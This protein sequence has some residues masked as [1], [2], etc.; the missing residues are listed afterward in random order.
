MVKFSGFFLCIVLASMALPIVHSTSRVPSVSAASY[1]IR[2]DGVLFAFGWSANNGEQWLVNNETNTMDSKA[3][4]VPP[5]IPIEGDG[6]NYQTNLYAVYVNNIGFDYG[7]STSTSDRYRPSDSMMAGGA[8]AFNT[9]GP[10]EPPTITIYGDAGPV[11]ANPSFIYF[12]NIGFS[13]VWSPNVGDKYRPSDSMIS[14]PISSFNSKAF[15]APSVPSDAGSPQENEA[16]IYLNNIGFSFGWSVNVNDRYRPSSTMEIGPL[17]SLNPNALKFPPSPA[18]GI[19]NTPPVTSDDYD[20]A[21]HNADFTI[22]LTAHDDLSGVAATYYRV[23]AGSIKRISIDGQPR[24]TTE[25]ANNT[26]EYWS[27]DNSANEELPHK[28]LF[29]IK[30]DKTSPVIWT[31]TR[32]PSGNVTANQAVTISANVT[33]SISG[34]KSARLE[35]NVSNSPL[36]WDFPMNLNSTTGLYEYTIP[37]QPAGALVKYKITA[38][39]YAGNNKV[40]DNAGQYYVY[41]VVPEFPPFLILPLFMIATLLAVIVFKRKKGK[42]LGC[43]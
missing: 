35:Y 8:L 20:G 26:L 37:G 18:V 33:D 29:G 24:I 43:E 4:A 22:T 9:K 25:S 27:V 23:N 14:G 16:L 13:T 15:S 39:D 30:L 34:V 28:T 6:G 42:V 11:Q 40:D 32:T 17:T 19:D 3:L 5:S 31:Q 1:V 2:V 36:L 41:I 21:W 38:Y 10:L 12:N 7:W